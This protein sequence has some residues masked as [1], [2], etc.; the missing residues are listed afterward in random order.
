[1]FSKF[2]SSVAL[3]AVVLGLLLLPQLSIAQTYYSTT[4]ATFGDQ[5]SSKDNRMFATTDGVIHFASDTGILLPYTTTSTNQ[6]LTAAQT[7]TTV[8]FNT[9]GGVAQDATKFTLPTAAVG[10]Q[11]T[12]V[13]DIAK[14]FYVDV[15]STDTIK[16]STATA[17]DRISNSATAAAGDSI[18]LFCATANTWSIKSK[19]GTWAV[20]PGQ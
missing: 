14:W 19:V 6:T 13:S 5:N 7:G 15:Q 16:Y 3:L 2:R 9:V 18:T 4:T 8:I 12:I 11:F 17:G 1:M 20:G 10:M